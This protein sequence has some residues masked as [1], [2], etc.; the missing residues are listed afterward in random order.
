[1]VMPVDTHW[2]MPTLGIKFIVMTGTSTSFTFRLGGA[3][4]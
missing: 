4:I 3:H 1:M 2:K